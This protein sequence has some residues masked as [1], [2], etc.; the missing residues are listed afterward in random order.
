[1]GKE[2]VL[3]G[4]LRGANLL[5]GKEKVLL[6]SFLSKKKNSQTQLFR[7]VQVWT[8]FY[9]QKETQLATSP[10]AMWRKYVGENPVFRLNGQATTAVLGSICGLAIGLGAGLAFFSET[11]WALGWYLLFLGFFHLSEYLCVA[12]F[13]P[14]LVSAECRPTSL[15]FLCGILNVSFVRSQPSSSIT[16][17][18]S[19]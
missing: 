4:S 19:T 6:G 18:N 9:T 3:L 10:G 1:M 12:V 13:N 7:G 14:N 2:K 17:L 15:P 16:A 8:K 5:M 11:L